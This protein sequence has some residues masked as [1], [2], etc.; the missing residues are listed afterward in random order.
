M[1]ARHKESMIEAVVVQCNRTYRRW[2]RRHPEFEK[3]GRVV[4]PSV[5]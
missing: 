5:A 2:C 4:N 1:T 3:K